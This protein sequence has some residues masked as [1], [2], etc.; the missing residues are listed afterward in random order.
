MNKLIAGVLIA[1]SMFFGTISTSQAATKEW[2]DYSSQQTL[3]I[4]KAEI[5]GASDLLAK[6]SGVLVFPSILKAGLGWGGE[7]GEGA[8]ITRGNAAPQAYYNLISVSFGFQF[9]IQSKSV[10]ICFMTDEALKDFQNTSGW[11]AGVD[12][13][14]AVIGVGANVGLDTQTLSSP[15]VAVVFDQKGLMYNLSLEGSKISR[16][17][18]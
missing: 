18:R 11:K 17:I 10:L 2:L 7:Y 5:P 15:V 14:I 16:I 3:Q 13:S 1:F 4:F 12:A 6:S 8:L 9:G